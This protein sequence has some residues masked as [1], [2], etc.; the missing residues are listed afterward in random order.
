MVL[1]RTHR[2]RAWI[3]FAAL[4]CLG[5][6]GVPPARAC[7]EFFHEDGMQVTLS[8]P[9][10]LQW[11]A[12]FARADLVQAIMGGQ[13]QYALGLSPEAASGLIEDIRDG[14]LGFML[15][16]LGCYK[17]RIYLSGTDSQV[18]DVI[19][20]F[21]E[22][23]TGGKEIGYYLLLRDI[24]DPARGSFSVYPSPP[25]YAAQEILDQLGRSERSQE[26]AQQ[27]LREDFG[28]R[29]LRDTVRHPFPRDL[30]KELMEGLGYRHVGPA[31]DRNSWIRPDEAG[32]P[33]LPERARFYRKVVAG[34]RWA[35]RNGRVLL[36]G[37]GFSPDRTAPAAAPP[38]DALPA[39][40]S[41]PSRL[42]HLITREEYRRR[43]PD[44]NGF[45]HTH[46]VS[47]H[48]F[49]GRSFEVERVLDSLL[50]DLEDLGLRYDAAAREWSPLPSSTP[51]SVLDE[52]PSYG[53]RSGESP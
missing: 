16:D 26:D 14:V 17:A 9:Y 30:E 42:P 40:G 52:T 50:E 13:G 10:E 18:L 32:G 34:I 22:G 45:F 47:M 51:T 4:A 29:D 48:D 6:I 35:E 43:Y 15:R 38:A 1:D 21:K 5:W 31:R 23:Q 39:G 33:E 41:R 49:D 27:A 7:T 24:D 25:K 8:N 12:M 46:T 53:V 37:R 11:D 2:W 36:D 20:A 3:G 28:I 44:G 19:P